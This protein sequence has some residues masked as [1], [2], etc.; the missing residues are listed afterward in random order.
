M[1]TALRFRGLT[2]RSV[3]NIPQVSSQRGRSAPHRLNVKVCPHAPCER[4]NM[5][6]VTVKC[7]SRHIDQ[8][9][10]VPSLQ[11]DL[12]SVAATIQGTTHQTTERET[13]RIQLRNHFRYQPWR[14]RPWTQ[15]LS[16]RNMPLG[17]KVT[18]ATAR[19]PILK[20][21]AMRWGGAGVSVL[22]RVRLA[23]G[24][25]WREGGEPYR[26]NLIIVLRRMR[27]SSIFLE[28]I[29]DKSGKL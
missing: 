11:F 5:S 22:F 25:Y 4:I 7:P 14:S 24:S 6:M 23:L 27:R 16:Q 19:S 2:R 8:V 13:A 28:S 18:R 15:Q 9:R 3:G 1:Q 12:A 17:N 21:L 26:F 10:C 20:K 29:L